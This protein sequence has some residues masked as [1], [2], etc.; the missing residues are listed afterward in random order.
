M[1]NEFP[2][3][4]K[5]MM[6]RYPGNEPTTPSPKVEEAP[7]TAHFRALGCGVLD[8]WLVSGDFG[9]FQTSFWDLSRWPP[10]LVHTLPEFATRVVHSREGHWL[11]FSETNPE[12]K[13]R[14][15]RPRLF[16]KLGK[17]CAGA[18]PV[19]VDGGELTPTGE[20]SR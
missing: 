19:V 16:T 14:S 18:F 8:G 20:V 13:P 17:P 3:D 11:L 7:L 1:A 10:P 4:P 5:L 2:G 15:F 6:A 12:A 9:P